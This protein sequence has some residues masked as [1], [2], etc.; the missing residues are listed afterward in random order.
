MANST[1]TTDRISLV[2]LLLRLSVFLVM[3]TLGLR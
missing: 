3:L 2:L 1:H